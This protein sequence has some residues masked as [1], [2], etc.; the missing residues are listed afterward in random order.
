MGEFWRFHFRWCFAF[1]KIP[2][3][4]KIYKDQNKL[5]VKYQFVISLLCFPMLHSD[6][7]DVFQAV[8]GPLAKQIEL[9]NFL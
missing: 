5:I 3:F 8:D 6:L 2:D 9:R 7:P 1:D 4:K